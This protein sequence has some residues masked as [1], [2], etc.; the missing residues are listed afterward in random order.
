[1]EYTPWT[2]A[3]GGAATCK[4]LCDGGY[5]SNGSEPKKCAKCE[6]PCAA[7][8]D[9]GQVGDTAKC[10]E[11]NRLGGYQF[12]YSP[13]SQCMKSCSTGFYEVDEN[14]CDKCT[15]PCHDCSGDKFNC[16]QCDSNSL[17]NALYSQV[18]EVPGRGSVAR[19]TCY[20]AC[21]NGYFF[22]NA[23]P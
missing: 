18:L 22:D 4:A 2:P 17:E 13:D 1:M 15:A 9:D 19:G 23:I 7:C 5:S 14:T 20:R 10:T 21:P 8:I 6:E 11:C 12:L 3:E 16:T